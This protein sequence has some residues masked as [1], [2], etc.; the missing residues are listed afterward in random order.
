MGGRGYHNDVRGYLNSSGR[1]SEYTKLD[2]ISNERFD[3]IIDSM[4][5]H[6]PLAPEFSNTAGKIYVLLDK[7]GTGIKNIT[8]YDKNHEQEYSIHLDHM[9]NG[10]S[11]PHVHS[12]MNTGRKEM[13]FTAQHQKLIDEATAIFNKRRKQ[14]WLEKI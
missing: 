5:P 8:V 10:K 12:G 6:A 2:T 9:H 7:H 13:P 3:F 1:T 11:G 14:K 4:Q